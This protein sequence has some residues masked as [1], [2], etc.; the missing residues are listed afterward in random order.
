[1]TFGRSIQKTG[2]EFVCFSFHL[3]LLFYQN[4]L[5]FKPDTKNKQV[6]HT[7]IYV[8]AAAANSTQMPTE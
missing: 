4:F 3:G 6:I 5:S 1:M 2:T 8:P 7:Y